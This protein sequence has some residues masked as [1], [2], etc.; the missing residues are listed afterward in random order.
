MLSLD[1][2]SA[3]LARNGQSI[4][5][6]TSGISDEQAAWQPA[7]DKWSVLGVINHLYHEECGDFR[8]HILAALNQPDLRPSQFDPAHRFDSLMTAVQ[9]FLDERQRSLAWLYNTDT[10][11]WQAT[12]TLHFGPITVGD[13]MAAWLAHD[14]LHMR[15]LVELN[16]AY[17]R[18]RL[19]PYRV[20]YAGD[21]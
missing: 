7:P 6:L 5:Q 4:R 2:I 10:L 3:E 13:L 20:A 18:Q 9:A 14:I 19:L 1:A 16:Y 8:F 12:A 15:Q 11:D 17:T 21:W